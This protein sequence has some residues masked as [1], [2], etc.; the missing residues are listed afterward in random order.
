MNALVSPPHAH[1][2]AE[3][4]DPV[5]GAIVA[6]CLSVAS[7]AV[8]LVVVLS[9]GLA[10]SSP[11]GTG[12]TVASSIGS[13]AQAMWRLFCAVAVIGVLAGACGRLT[14]RLGL[15]S[16]TGEILAGLLIG[17]SALGR[18]APDWS[19]AILPPDFA[20][21]LNLIAQM[22]LVLFM[23]AVGREFDLSV[24]KRH[25]YLVGAAGQAMMVVPFALGVLAAIPF[26][27]VMAGP[28][29]AFLPLVVFIGTAVS[30]SAFPVLARIVEESG[31]ADTFLGTL[32]LVC[33]AVADVLVWCAL[34][35]V[36][37]LTRANATVRAEWALAL[38]ALMVVALFLVVKPVLQRTVNRFEHRRFSPAARLAA[39]VGLVFALSAATDAIGVHAIFG[40]VLAGLVF[41]RNARWWGDTPGQLDSV[42]RALLLPMFFA[43][44]GMQVDVWNALRQPAI[45]AAGGV[46]LIVAIG[47]KFVGAFL[48]ARAGGLST[49]LSLGLG[50]LT[51]TR[52]ITEI[53]VLSTGL[54]LGVINTEAFTVLVGMGLATTVMAAPALRMLGLVAATPNPSS[55]TL[56]NAARTRRASQENAPA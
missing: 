8:V 17:P 29:A 25:P 21:D 1:G 33:A 38:S 50:A 18:I 36:I 35:V 32:A 13:P 16:V 34:A 48:I 6:V 52:G 31:I 56:G 45:V 44:V 47:G 3:L 51:N 9:Q 5:R 40:G 12:P 2:S 24:L 53:V 55:L 43:S 46:L 39:L 7:V 11:A 37:T 54:S 30:V 28:Q 14:R 23:F 15:S 19:A 4:S 22:A 20:P 42:N 49:R 10:S 27:G 26:Y 41:P